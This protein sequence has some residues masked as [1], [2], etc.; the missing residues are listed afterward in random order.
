MDVE[1]EGQ[2]L[3]TLMEEHTGVE[4]QT[5]WGEEKLSKTVRVWELDRGCGSHR[6][7]GSERVWE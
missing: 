6:G 5:E 7:C 1:R 2:H 4:V 3:V